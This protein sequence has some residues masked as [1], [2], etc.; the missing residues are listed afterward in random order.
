M[1]P[2]EKLGLWD[3]ISPYANSPYGGPQAPVRPD[4]ASALGDLTEEERRRLLAA[5]RAGMMGSMGRGFQDAISMGQQIGGPRGQ[6]PKVAALVAALGAG[7]SG[8]MEQKALKAGLEEQGIAQ[9]NALRQKDYALQRQDFDDQRAEYRL[10]EQLRRERER[11]E[12]A[13]RERDAATRKKIGEE[14]RLSEAM[15]EFPELE[16]MDP[17]DP[18]VAL[19]LPA[20]V[21][22][23]Y[24]PEKETK[25][26]PTLIYDSVGV[27]N[28]V[29]PEGGEVKL[30]RLPE[31]EKDG[32]S[33][34]ERD[35]NT[36]NR[37]LD[38]RIAAINR[39]KPHQRS[40]EDVKFLADPEAQTAFRDQVFSRYS[41]PGS[42][43]ASDPLDFAKGK[44]YE[45]Q[46]KADLAA[47]KSV[48][49]IL[50]ELREAGLL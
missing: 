46:V 39:K 30:R 19:A 38:Q 41:A 32:A 10:E 50:K 26:K 12:A 21:K 37:A 45:A 15:R 7:L 25:P 13:V 43:K 11:E 20:L 6:N 31:K 36:A 16:G 44:P 24:A 28:M 9:A 1:F 18:R 40:P 42:T 47:G 2:F 23:K 14:L 29:I 5:Q 3:A 22:A 34:R 4:L 49:Q 33:E 8:Y 35:W 17:K 48:A 27:R